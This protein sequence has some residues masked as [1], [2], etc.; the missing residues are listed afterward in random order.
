MSG[1]GVN[2]VHTELPPVIHVHNK[3]PFDDYDAAVAALK[4]KILHPGEIVV[5]Y[6]KDPKTNDGISTL[7]ATGPI[8]SG[9][10]NEVFKNANEI[11]KLVDYLK[12]LINA[13]EQSIEELARNLETQ[14]L[15]DVEV[16]RQE[17]IT[18]NTSLITEAV[19]ALNE[20][21]DA[22]FVEM[23]TNVNERLDSSLG[24]FQRTLEHT[25]DV[26]VTSVSNLKTYVDGSLGRLS[27]HLNASIIEIQRGMERAFD[28]EDASMKLYVDQKVSIEQTRATNAESALSQSIAN[29]STS[30]NN[31]IAEV[32]DDLADE[33]RERK[34]DL[35]T[36][37]SREDA[38]LKAYTNQLRYDMNN[39]IS[40]TSSALAAYTDA[41]VE[42]LRTENETQHAELK[43]ELIEYTD[44]SVSRLRNEVNSKLSTLDSSV[45]V[46]INRSFTEAKN[47]TDNL[48]SSTDRNLRGYSDDNDASLKALLEDEISQTRD[49]L[50]VD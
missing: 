48:V 35:S 32:A 20:R 5:V 30:L 9:G 21:F 11:D 4:T 33:I 26:L 12:G 44:A 23:N 13:Q 46:H 41:S 10:Y 1:V 38:S 37:I 2:H 24:E 19:Y 45:N 43:D 50:E 16:L 6:Y 31:K 27:D 22:S 29:V 36:A 15:A 8:Q 14:I 47:Y 25:T 40:N 49:A 7:I 42:A 3:I 18:E 28:I 34:Q 17:I 39:A